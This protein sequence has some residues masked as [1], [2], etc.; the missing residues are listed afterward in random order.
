MP[1][2]WIAADQ[3][4]DSDTTVIICMP[5]AIEPIWLGYHDGE[6]WFIVEGTAVSDLPD[7]QGE[8]TAWRELPELPRGGR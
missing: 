2:E 6:Q 4:P 8:V 3:L 7:N 1:S 5:D